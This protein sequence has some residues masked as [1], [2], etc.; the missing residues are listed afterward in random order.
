MNRRQFIFSS[1]AVLATAS[2]GLTVYQHQQVDGSEDTASLV[3]D[4][5]LPA[6]LLG[7]LPKNDALSKQQLLTTREAALEYLKF[8]SVHQQQE[9]HKLFTALEVSLTRLALTGHWVRL[10]DLAVSEK[11]RLLDSW[12]D[13]YLLLLQQAY[14]GCKELLLGSYYG[15]PQ[16]WHALNYQAPEFNPVTVQTTGVL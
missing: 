5:L 4:A 9:L 1:L 11:L 12:R 2:A 14:A 13:S 7:A 3:L 10:A 15:L 6:L 8:L 16:H